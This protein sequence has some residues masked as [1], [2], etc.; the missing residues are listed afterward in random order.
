MFET[1]VKKEISILDF[2]IENRPLSY[3][4]MDWTTAEITAIACSWVGEK[5]VY[6]WALGEDHPTDMLREFFQFYNE[7]DMV[8]GHYIRKHD[9]PIING[10]LLEYGLPTLDEKR[11]QDTKLDLVRKRDLSASQ[12]SLAMMYGLPEAKHHM[13][14]PEWRE[15][16]RLT[17]DGIKY[18]KKRVIDDVKQHKA[19]REIL[20][21]NNALKSPKMWR[22]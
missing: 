8:T 15:A 13:S 19:L 14:Q 11:T 2:D 3:A 18:T 21:K 7:A 22:P 20:V 5:K 12:E 9:L 4:G 1:R 6:V 17:P 10:A 16:N